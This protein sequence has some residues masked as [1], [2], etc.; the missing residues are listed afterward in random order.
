MTAHGSPGA[1]EGEGLR[2]LDPRRYPERLSG[3]R[4]APPLALV[5]V[6]AGT[7]V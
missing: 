1:L 6:K 7:A 3:S 4:R 2:S 5:E